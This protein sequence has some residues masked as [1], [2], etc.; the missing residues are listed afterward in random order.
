MTAH[1]RD[2]HE[3]PFAAIEPNQNPL[4]PRL[5]AFE[6]RETRNPALDNL[7]RLHENTIAARL[8]R[9]LCLR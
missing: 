3:R 7:S 8:R 4:A 1:L 6:G 9:H 2:V 5:V